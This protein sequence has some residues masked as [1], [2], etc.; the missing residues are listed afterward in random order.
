MAM[1]GRI[2]T[3][4]DLLA[5][6]W[7]ALDATGVW[8]APE[9]SAEIDPAELTAIQ[10]AVADSPVPLSLVVQPLS[11]RDAF[12]GE[13]AELLTQLHD[14]YDADGLYL[15]PQFYG[16]VESLNLV[17][18]AW[19]TDRDAWEA[20]AVAEHRH[21][22]EDRNIADLGAYLADVT[23]LV[24]NGDARAAYDEEVAPAREA[25]STE[26]SVPA[27]SPESSSDGNGDLAL[28]AVLGAGVLVAAI[29]V[30]AV[31]RR[32]PRT[33]TLPDSVVAQ[34]REAHADR[35]ELE[36]RDL[37]LEL[38]EAVRRSDLDTDHDTGAWQ[39]ALDH[40]DAATRVLDGSDDLELLDAVG[41]L[42]L[43]RQA[44]AALDA[45]TSG[46][47]FRRLR[48]CYLNPLHDGPGRTSMRL[49]QEGHTL[50][51]PVCRTCRSD[52]KAGRDP[53]AL[54][55]ERRGRAVLY[56]DSGVEPWASTAYGT[57]GTGLVG[58]LHRRR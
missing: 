48:L 49:E 28:V 58:A 2:G 9:V 7:S 39:A 3:D 47:T 11:D 5:T 14:R 54:R 56:V 13:P 25:A 38:G 26:T 29:V 50:D 33:F 16:D 4:E 46:K 21:G 57:L 34:V 40:Y 52:L 24:A 6:I 22:D 45:A 10:E 31:R 42:V 27:A 23:R 20:D 53:D 30:A 55:V 32:G 43:A 8:V 12:G 1:T 35:I 44:R 17:E 15:A 51:V 37:V 36:A 18:R 41:A 19:G